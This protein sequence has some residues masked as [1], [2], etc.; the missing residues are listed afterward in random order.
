ML[1]FMAHKSTPN[2]DKF[3]SEGVI[4]DNYYVQPICF[5][6]RGALLTGMCPIHTGKNAL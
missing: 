4:L 5:P 6:T 2:I 1:G 3:A